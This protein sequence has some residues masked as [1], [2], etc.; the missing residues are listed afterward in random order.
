MKPKVKVKRAIVVESVVKNFRFGAVS[1][2]EMLKVE[3]SFG[4]TESH[5]C[6]RYKSK[7]RMFLMEDP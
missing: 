5:L 7:G 1:L 3:F 2:I 6:L 4:K